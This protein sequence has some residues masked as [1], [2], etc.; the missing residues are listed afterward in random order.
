[1]KIK[2]LFLHYEEKAHQI[3]DFIILPLLEA[4]FFIFQTTFGMA[5]ASDGLRHEEKPDGDF[6]FI[7]CRRS[8][9]IVVV[10]KFTPKILQI[11]FA[12][13]A[14]IRA[15]VVLGLAAV[16]NNLFSSLI[17]HS[18]LEEYF[19]Y[20]DAINMQAGSVP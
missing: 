4:H 5:R 16:G 14:R 9:L 6:G 11:W 17:K 13:R 20:K 3:Y 15:T 19:G 18:K 1:Y 7:S 8:F 2:Y 12:I 10:K